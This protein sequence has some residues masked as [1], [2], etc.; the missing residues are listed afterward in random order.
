[1]WSLADTLDRLAPRLDTA[2][3]PGSALG[4]VRAV[5]ARLPAH[6]TRHVYLECWPGHEP[7]RV[8][9]LVGIEAENRALL[10][11]TSLAP[12]EWRGQASWQRVA[13]WGRAWSEPDSPLERDVKGTWLEFDLDPT[14]ATVD[15]LA[16]PRLFVDFHG[17]AQRQATVGERARL[18]LQV[19]P[20]LC[21]G[22]DLDPRTVHGVRACLELL[23]NDAVLG[24]VGVALRREGPLVR[25]CIW[26]LRDRLADYLRAV[27][28]PGD[29]AAL[30]R[31]V[32][33][34]LARASGRCGAVS[35]LHLDVSSDVCSRVGLEY[36][37]SRADQAKG[38]IAETDLLDTL[39]ALGWC[40][41]ASRDA[42]LRWPGR[43]VELLDHEIWHSRV[44]WR[45]AHV[46]L[47]FAPHGPVRLKVYLQLRFDLLPGGAMLG[48]RPRWF[49][50]PRPP[51]GTP[52]RS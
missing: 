34:P 22:R 39:V 49:A 12:A 13:T 52:A 28:W 8:D 35:V 50:T 10:A 36:T 17:E 31:V 26:R 43:T 14:S 4:R 47:T 15:A 21:G 44:D 19:L 1:M 48:T 9:L 40:P 5:A 20:A 30:T 38:R 24:S 32:L 46:K 37:L 33:D 29:V 6:L 27:R 2:L 42:L 16:Q 45:V 25:I 18:A 11:E 41:P 23:P 7:P 51:D 3:V